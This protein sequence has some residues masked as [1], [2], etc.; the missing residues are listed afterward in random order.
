MAK[1]PKTWKNSDVAERIGIVSAYVI[2]GTI[3]VIMLTLAFK[4]IEFIWSL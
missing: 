3:V 4:L 1:S 2:V